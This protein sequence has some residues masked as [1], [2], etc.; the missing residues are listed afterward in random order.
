MSKFWSYLKNIKITKFKSYLKNIKITKF[1]SYLKNIKITK[2]KSY[3]KNIKITK[4]KSYLIRNNPREE[5]LL[6]KKLIENSKADT[7]E[8]TENKLIPNLES[9]ETALLEQG[10]LY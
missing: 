2:F 6:Q 3:L 4:F 8:K 9:R 10:D 7:S 5:K 1:K